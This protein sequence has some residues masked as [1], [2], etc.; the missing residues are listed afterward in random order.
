MMAA[1]AATV[2]M[3]AGNSDITVTVSGDA[4]LKTPRPPSR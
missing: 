2:A 4:V 3:E 1:K